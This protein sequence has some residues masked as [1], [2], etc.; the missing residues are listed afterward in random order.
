MGENKEI[1]RDFTKSTDEEIDIK[2]TIKKTVLSKYL[3]ACYYVSPLK[4][5]EAP[6]TFA[7]ILG[8]SFDDVVPLDQKFFNKVSECL[9]DEGIYIAL[10]FI[11]RKTENEFL[12]IAGDKEKIIFIDSPFDDVLEYE[13]GTLDF[14]NVDFGIKIT[15]N[16]VIYGIRYPG[17]LMPSSPPYFKEYSLN[18]DLEELIKKTIVFK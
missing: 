5:N 6:L 16:E 9:G 12:I 4:S 17:D 14:D 10:A 11:K 15:K 3:D 18:K 1:K 7:E 2:A 8:L 13:F